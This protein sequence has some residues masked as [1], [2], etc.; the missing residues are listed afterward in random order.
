MRT[1]E[2]RLAKIR[3]G[4]AKRIPASDLALMHAATQTLVDSRLH[5]AAKG[6]GDAAPDFA[7]PN[8]AGDV[9]SLASLLSRGPAVIAFFRGHW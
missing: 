9:V 6:E 8:S 2:E 5:E 7:L 4:S 3:E 1:L